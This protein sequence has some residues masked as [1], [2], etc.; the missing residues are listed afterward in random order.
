MKSLTLLTRAVAE[1]PPRHVGQPVI[2][3]E[4][5][6]LVEESGGT[7]RLRVSRPLLTQLAAKPAELHSLVLELGV[8]RVLSYEGTKDKYCNH[9]C[10]VISIYSPRQTGKVPE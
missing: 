8:V 2:G 9:K 3:D 6:V 5:P 1:A 7:V 4:V 10:G